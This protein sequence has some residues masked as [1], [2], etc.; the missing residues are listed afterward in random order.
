MVIH[1]RNDSI[2]CWIFPSNLKGV[3]SDWFYSLLPRSIHRFEYLT[4]LFITQYSSRQAFKQNNHYLLS[5]KMKLSHSL[6]V[7]IGYFQNQLAKVH[8]CSEDVSALAFI[9][10]L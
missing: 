7:Y 10:R 6:K 4:K 9:G 8:N 2:L 5:I 1:A 3:A